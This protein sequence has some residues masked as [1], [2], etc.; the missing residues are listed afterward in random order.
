MVKGGSE[1]QRC[2]GPLAT[3]RP[4][5]TGRAETPWRTKAIAVQSPNLISRSKSP[6]L[7]PPLPP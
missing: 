1:S 2:A 6:D 7:I 5:D 3:T 4:D